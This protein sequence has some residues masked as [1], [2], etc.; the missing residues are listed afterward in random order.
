M[1]PEQARGR[2]VDKR[3]DI[4]AFGV[5]LYEML[6][7]TR[8]FDGETISDTLASVLK[9]EPDLTQVPERARRVLRACLE[10]DP[11]KRLRDIGDFR[12]WCQEAEPDAVAKP[13]RALAWMGVS[14]ILL[15]VALALALVHLREA[16]PAVQVIRFSI[17]IP[18]NSRVLLSFYALSPD[19]RHIVMSLV[20]GGK[21]HLWLRALDSPQVRLLS[22]TDNGRTPFWSADSRSIGFFA[23]GKLKTVPAGGGP[24]QVLCDAGLGAGGTWNRDGVIL[25]NP[26]NRGQLHRVGAAGGASTPVT[27]IEGGNTLFSPVFLPDG[28]HFLYSLTGGDEDKGGVF[29]AAL[30]N[31]TGR[32][33][34]T[35]RSPVRFAPPTSGTG[36][37]HLLFLRETTLMAQP[38]DAG[39][40]QLAGDAFPVAG[41]AA[42]ASASGNGLLAYVANVIPDSQLTWFDRSGKEQAKVGAPGNLA[43][44]VSLSPDEK[45]V[46]FSRQGDLWM[47]SLDRGVETR[48]TFPP[49]S[50]ATAV[51]APDG[52]RIA[53]SSV[54]G[55]LYRKDAGGG[56]QEE[57]LLPKGNEKYPSDWSRDGRYLLYTEVDP[58][59]RGDLWI[60]PDPSAKPGGEKPVSFLRTE[61][62]ESQGQFSPDGRWIAYVSDQSG[63]FEVYVRPFPAAAGQVRVS[64]TG[65][66]EPRWSRDGKELFYLE[67]VGVMRRLMTVPIRSGSNK[68]FDVGAP[69]PLFE[70]RGIGFIPQSNAFSYSVAGS[71]QRFL[72]RNEASTAEPTL[73]VILN[74]EKAAKP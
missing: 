16:P 8:L 6:T 27:Q 35:D 10:K 70:F 4:W 3:A 36:H 14:G 20:T 44:V 58:K 7:G 41:P 69:K 61:F 25:F 73:N 29:L 71:G 34:L 65:G 33:I 11:K 52:G 46:A 64:S 31:P 40:L 74:W 32:R 37:G 56:G 45:N 59:T 72:A 1:A 26:G 18:E 19:G 15:L 67:L 57:L 42:M 2:Q 63:Q 51:W 28:K 9:S 22:G 30:D 48:F 5:V 17:A 43:P 66:R 62:M 54:A 60:L 13:R 12:I 55:E 53:F 39:K 68:V 21:V 49:L 50:G 47:H 38:F 23:D 24:A